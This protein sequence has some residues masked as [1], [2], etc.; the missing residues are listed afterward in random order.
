[1]TDVGSLALPFLLTALAFA[2]IT[3]L[4]A[5]SRD[6][7]PLIWS[8][9]GVLLGPIALA[10]VVFAPPGRCGS[11][12]QLVEGWPSHCAVCGALLPTPLSHQERSTGPAP[13]GVVGVPA[14]PATPAV[15]EALPSIVRPFPASIDAEPERPAS[16]VTR[17]GP[18]RAEA[19]PH[20]SGQSPAAVD[21]ALLPDT[22]ETRVLATAVYVTGS[23]SLEPGRRYT[24]AI[25]G[26]RLRF[27]GPVDMDPSAVALDHAVG[28]VDATAIEGRLIVS[29]A[30]GRSLLVL[31]F[32]AVAGATP[33]GLAQAIVDAARSSGQT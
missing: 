28:D 21:R 4:V 26:S 1:M 25:H 6:R 33:D 20:R 32:M 18:S 29:D 31:A 17:A 16:V 23:A 14:T 11:C 13:L 9:L 24:I 10:L 22:I 3:A 5:R 15:P 30:G 12:G 27:L 8:F 7:Q 19:R 2:P